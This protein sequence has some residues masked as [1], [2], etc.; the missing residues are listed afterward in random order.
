MVSINFQRIIAD[1]NGVPH[2]NNFKTKDSLACLISSLFTY[3][4]LRWLEIVFN[5]L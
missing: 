5:S 4:N 1:D 2:I 3:I